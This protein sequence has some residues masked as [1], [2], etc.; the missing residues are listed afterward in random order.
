MPEDPGAG[1]ISTKE[2][3]G[4]ADGDQVEER[5]GKLYSEG[6]EISPMQAASLGW[7]GPPL[8]PKEPQSEDLPDDED[9]TRVANRE[10]DKIRDPGITQDERSKAANGALDRMLSVKAAPEPT[11]QDVNMVA[12]AE[13]LEAEE[14]EEGHREAPSDRPEF[15]VTL[16]GLGEDEYVQIE[17]N[18][19]RKSTKQEKIIGAGDYLTDQS[20]V[21]R[22]SVIR[23]MLK[24]DMTDKRLASKETPTPH[25]VIQKWFLAGEID[26]LMQVVTDISGWADG[27]L[28]R[29]K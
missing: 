5:G 26:Q 15:W 4:P 1:A 27:A 10:Q 6:A 28:E 3:I 19:R 2:P 9:G 24:P 11:T 12:F 16:R 17:K 23:S 25:H 7:Q 8:E 14:I 20:M 21:K 29:A 18:C 13:R 22:I